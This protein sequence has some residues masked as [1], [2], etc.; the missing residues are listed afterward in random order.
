MKD[1]YATKESK[2]AR[3]VS[4][5]I[6]TDMWFISVCVTARYDADL[7]H[8]ATGVSRLIADAFGGTGQAPA[9]A[10]T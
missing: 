2:P 3:V 8:V 1:W 5:N 10:V 9:S 6:E 4:V 7:T